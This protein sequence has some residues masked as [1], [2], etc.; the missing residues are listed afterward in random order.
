MKR[1]I[2]EPLFHFLLIGAFL[3]FLFHLINNT[4]QNSKEDI[5]I[6]TNELKGLNGRCNGKG[7]L[8]KKN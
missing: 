3:F 4:Q 7:N 1:I 5:I 2:R 8:L 6:D